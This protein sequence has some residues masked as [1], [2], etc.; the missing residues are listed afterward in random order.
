MTSKMWHGVVVATN[1]ISIAGIIPVGVMAKSKE[2]AIE[3]LIT[4]GKKA[5]PGKTIE[6]YAD[7]AE[8]SDPE[9]FISVEIGGV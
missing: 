3:K 1:L 9:T 4:V 8:F 7:T 6:A 2:D 5:F